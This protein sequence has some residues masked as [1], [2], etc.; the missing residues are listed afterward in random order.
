MFISSSF[1]CSLEF[2]SVNHTLIY[3]NFDLKVFKNIK[4]LGEKISNNWPNNLLGKNV[5]K[6][7][8]VCW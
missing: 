4:F 6:T 1:F 7:L 2:W 3:E 5:Y 8:E